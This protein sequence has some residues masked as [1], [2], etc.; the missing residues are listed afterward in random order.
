MSRIQCSGTTAKGIA[1]T[2][3]VKNI[4]DFCHLHKNSPRSNEKSE[5][6]VCSDECGICLSEVLEHEDCG[7]ICEHRFHVECLKHIIKAE[8]PICRGPL[9]F[10]EK[11]NVKNRISVKNIIRRE[12]TEKERVRKETLA[13]DA[14]LARE[15]ENNQPLDVSIGEAIRDSLFTLELEDYDMLAGIIEESYYFFQAEEESRLPLRIEE[16]D[17][18]EYFRELFVIHN[19]DRLIIKLK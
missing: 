2:K 4:G 5:S 6:K 9:I 16:E 19:T 17:P 7:L 18:V 3:P 1:C 11:H 10:K 15:I 12:A 8:C 14:I 13:K